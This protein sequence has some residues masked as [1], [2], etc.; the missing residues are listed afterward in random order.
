[1]TPDVVAAWTGRHA[2]A[3]RQALRMTNER[4]A[5]HLGVAVRTVA[6]WR[7]RPDV[8][9]MPGTQEILDAALAQAT[10]RPKSNSSCCSPRMSAANPL[11][12]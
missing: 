5:E 8:V 7:A 10:E 3:L 6:N 9:P 12:Q 1:M 2:D 4:F 11:P